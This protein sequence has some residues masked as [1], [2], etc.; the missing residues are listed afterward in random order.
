MAEGLGD[1]AEVA[2]EEGEFGS[3]SEAEA[4]GPIE[5][6]S[7]S[8]SES[9]PEA[10]PSSSGGVAALVSGKGFDLRELGDSLEAQQLV[11]QAVAK[12]EDPKENWELYGAMHRQAAHDSE[13]FNAVLL[14]LITH[15]EVR[16]KRK[17]PSVRPS[18]MPRKERRPIVLTTGYPSGH[19]PSGSYLAES[20][21][22]WS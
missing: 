21:P 9:E 5:S 3:D 4:E 12:G 8:E 15:Y 14:H 20:Y 11:A 18:G 6:H 22:R 10:A 17:V 2:R 7:E 19:D 16:K 1:A 13:V